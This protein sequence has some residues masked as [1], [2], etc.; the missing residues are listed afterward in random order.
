MATN[1]MTKYYRTLLLDDRTTVCPICSCVN[2]HLTGKDCGHVYKITA[3]GV[4]WYYW[5]WRPEGF[6]K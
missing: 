1:K 6:G 2:R 4:V 5:A 3:S